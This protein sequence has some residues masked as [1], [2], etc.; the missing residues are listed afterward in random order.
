[1]SSSPV[2]SV[3]VYRDFVLSM[4]SLFCGRL[5]P[6][7]RPPPADLTGK[8]TVV[9][10]AN[11]GLGFQIALDLARQKATVFLACRNASKAQEAISRITSAVPDSVDRVKALSL[12]TSSPSSVRE[13]AEGWKN[14]ESKI[15]ILFN[16]AGVPSSPEQPFT[17]DGFPTTYATNFLGSFLL[18]QLLEP[19]LSNEARV[20]FTSSTGHYISDFTPT[21]S[22]EA[23]KNRLEPGF[24]APKAAVR[25]NGSAADSTIY[26]NTKAMQIA[27]AK[28]LQSRWN[29]AAKASGRTNERVVHAFSPGFTQ[30]PGLPKMTPLSIWKYSPLQVWED[31][32]FWLLG[33][34]TVLA[35][36]VS[37]GAATAVWLA[38]TKDEAVA[39]EGMG[40]GYWERMTKRAAT[41][42]AMSTEMLERFWIRWE[43]DA[44]IT[45]R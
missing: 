23:V 8:I 15:D 34:T 25:S 17:V 13:C 4:L 27:F 40:G 16:N 20:I 6:T 21:F 36:D 2:S 44:G 24:H 31:R 22:L 14:T 12:D 3:Y 41:V 18:T 35:T 42:D 45:W 19:C 26:G 43:A 37:Q 7:L 11:S 39:G 5:Y 33:A 30:T 38:T 28:L 29:A 10:G 32:G 9:T 1:M